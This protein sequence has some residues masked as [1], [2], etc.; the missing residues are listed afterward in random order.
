MNILFSTITGDIL[1]LIPVLLGGVLLFIISPSKVKA[2]GAF[3][4]IVS[5]LHW[6]WNTAF[7][8]RES[9][10]LAKAEHEFAQAIHDAKMIAQG[11]TFTNKD[12]EALLQV[13]S[14]FNSSSV[15]AIEFVTLVFD[16]K[17]MNYVNEL[18]KTLEKL[19]WKIKHIMSGLPVP[20]YEGLNIHTR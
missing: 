5:L 19:G 20:G 16:T 18:K 1:S 2:V 9:Q 3:I 7:Q 8:N 13:L 10:K 15:P 11:R 17:N 4:V 12:S 14:K 6:A